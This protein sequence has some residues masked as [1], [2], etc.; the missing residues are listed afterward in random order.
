MGAEPFDPAF[1]RFKRYKPEYPDAVSPVKIEPGLDRSLSRRRSCPI[2]RGPRGIYRKPLPLS[3]AMPTVLNKDVVKLENA[4]APE[5][6]EPPAKEN[7]VPMPEL[8]DYSRS[9]SVGARV[10]VQYTPQGAKIVIPKC[11]L[12]RSALGRSVRRSICWQFVDTQQ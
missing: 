9:N 4:F 8:E 11:L 10:T 3:P 12:G 6:I 5:R 1:P 7:N 2:P